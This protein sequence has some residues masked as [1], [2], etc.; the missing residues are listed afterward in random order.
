MKGI[1]GRMFCK[2][3]PIIIKKRKICGKR[4]EETNDDKNK[5]NLTSK[6]TFLRERDC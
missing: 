6:L 5:K 3:T 1:L 2:K 4:R